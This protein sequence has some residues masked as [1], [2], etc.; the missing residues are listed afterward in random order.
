M[1]SGMAPRHH[2]IRQLADAALRCRC[3]Y[4]RHDVAQ[5]FMLNIANITPAAT[6]AFRC[7]IPYVITTRRYQRASA[8]RT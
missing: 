7:L 2:A 6:P 4:T 5:S 1:T 3:R 8:C